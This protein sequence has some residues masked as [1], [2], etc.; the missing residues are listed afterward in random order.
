MHLACTWFSCPHCQPLTLQHVEPARHI[1]TPPRPPAD[2]HD[3]HRRLVSLPVSARARNSSPLAPLAKTP[4]PRRPECRHNNTNR[5]PEVTCCADARSVDTQDPP[6]RAHNSAPGGGGR[7][8]RRGAGGGHV[9]VCA[10]RV[11]A[12]RI[13]LHNNACVRWREKMLRSSLINIYTDTQ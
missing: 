4:P 7:R 8:W 11:Y 10:P 12:V 9:H 6:W 3:T 5:A 13:V 2:R 1:T